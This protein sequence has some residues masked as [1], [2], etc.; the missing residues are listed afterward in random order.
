MTY[1]NT[2]WTIIQEPDHSIKMQHS[3]GTNIVLSPELVSQIWLH[4]DEG[5]QPYE[6]DVWL[7]EDDEDWG[8]LNFNKKDYTSGG[9]SY[10]GITGYAL[11]ALS[12]WHETNKV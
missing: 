9:G 1:T 8:G 7:I 6:K 11:S 10:W 2:Q 12:D 3:N 5:Q 4:L